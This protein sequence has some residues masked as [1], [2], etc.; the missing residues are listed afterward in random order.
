MKRRTVLFILVLSLLVVGSASAM[1][2]NESRDLAS[3]EYTGIQEIT[4]ESE[5][6]DVNVVGTRTDRTTITVV[7]D[8]SVSVRIRQRGRS[9][10]VEAEERRAL[11]SSSR[12]EG[13]ID[14]QTFE[15]VDLDLET[16]SGAVDVR[17]LQAGGLDVNTGSGNIV[18]RSVYGEVELRSGS[19][20]IEMERVGGEVEA[21][22]ASGRVVLKDGEGRLTI[23]STSGEVTVESTRGNL[24]AGSTSGDIRLADLEGVFSVGTTSGSIR[25]SD[26]TLRGS[27]RF[28]SVSGSIQIDVSGD[29]ERFSY[30]M[31]TV[32]G[33]IRVGET[34]IGGRYERGGAGTLIEA[35]TV[36]GSITVE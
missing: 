7:G 23:R 24:E 18:A 17:G 33:D 4:V 21:H 8:P 30:A 26:L 10:L 15:G 32:S 3:E 25:S 19:G 6:F 35:S 34:R 13:T 27:S 5:S 1:G 28:N 20:N 14:I 16:G 11:F 12:Y 31:Q 9:V 22:S 29:P 36:S 2:G